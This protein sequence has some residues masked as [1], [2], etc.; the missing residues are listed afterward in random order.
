MTFTAEELDLI[1]IALSYTTEHGYT[2]RD[3]PEI[4]DEYQ[5]MINLMHFMM[6]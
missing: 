5:R 6:T 4:E 2:F 1:F 3:D